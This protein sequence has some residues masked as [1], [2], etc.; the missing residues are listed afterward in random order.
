MDAVNFNLDVSLENQQAADFEQLLFTDKEDRIEEETTFQ[1][2]IL[3]PSRIKI[4][5]ILF[6]DV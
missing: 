6:S 3:L 1:V 2:F 5:F 4:Q